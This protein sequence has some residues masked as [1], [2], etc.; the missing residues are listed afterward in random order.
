MIVKETDL[1]LGDKMKEIKSKKYQ[2]GEN[3]EAEGS[4]RELVRE[5]INRGDRVIVNAGRFQGVSGQVIDMGVGGNNYKVK[6]DTGEVAIIFPK[7]VQKE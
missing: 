1:G 3:K 5:V 4:Y 2:T 7:D 6:L